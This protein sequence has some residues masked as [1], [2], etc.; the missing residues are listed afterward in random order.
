MREVAIGWVKKA[1]ED[2]KAIKILLGAN[3]F[4]PSVVGF[5]AQQCVEKYL[6]AFLVDHGAKPP[7]IHD[8]V[9]LNSRCV[10]I[11]PNFKGI[12]DSLHILNPFSIGIRYPDFETDVEE[13]REAVKN[14]EKV[15]DFV[16]KKLG[17]KDDERN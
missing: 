10:E 1:E 8:L 12:S 9:E 6:K 17:V 3:E 16:R 7:R 14:A 5:H 2:Y 15:R 13:A 11:D 4:P